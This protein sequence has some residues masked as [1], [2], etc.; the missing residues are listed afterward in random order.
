MDEL[1]ADLI[2]A[3]RPLS[4][5]PS[6]YSPDSPKALRQYKINALGVIHGIAA[7]LPLLRASPAPLRK[8]VVI[9]TGGADPKTVLK[10]GIPDMA[11]YG[12][13]KAAALM[14][15]TKYALKLKDERFVVVSITPGIVDTSATMD[16]VDQ[17]ECTYPSAS[18]LLLIACFGGGVYGR[19]Q[20]GEGE[21]CAGGG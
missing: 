14:A 21:A 16:D 1:D 12:M 7:F 2:D 9:N 18:T 5:S 20:E 11:A 4:S 19:R 17:S 13:T 3:V 8:I 6:P 15:T 10:I